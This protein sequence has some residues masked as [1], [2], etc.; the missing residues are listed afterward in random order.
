MRDRCGC[1]VAGYDIGDAETGRQQVA[2]RQVGLAELDDVTLGW[3]SEE[4]AA[5]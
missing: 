3:V 1:V 2:A 4:V 5:C